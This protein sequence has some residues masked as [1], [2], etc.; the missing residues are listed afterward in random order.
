MSQEMQLG[1]ILK[2]QTGSGKNY[3]KD[4]R[5]LILNANAIGILRKDL[6][7]TLGKEKAKGFLI[8]FGFNNGFRD[9]NNV[10]H[11]FPRIDQEDRYHLARNFHT[12]IGMANVI[13]A[14]KKSNELDH[15]W[16]CEGCWHDSYEAEHHIK[17]FGSATEPVCWTLVGYASGIMSAF[18]GERVI[19]KEVSCVAMGDQ[20]CR[21]VGKKLSDWGEEIRPELQY[22]H[23]T[24][25][26]QG[27]EWPQA[28]IMEQNQALM[29]AVAVH[30]Q[31]TKMVLNGDDMSTIT[32]AVGKIM[33]GAV[34][35]EDHSFQPVSYFSPTMTTEVNQLPPFTTKNIISD[36]RLRHLAVKLTQENK[37]VVLPSE[38][39]KRPITQFVFPI[40]NRMEVI[41]YVSLIK[42]EKKLTEY[43]QM[44][45]EFVVT[46]LALKMMQDSTVA[47]TETRLLGDFVLELITGNFKSESSIVER[48]RCL[49]YKIKRSHRVL[50]ASLDKPACSLERSTRTEG[51]TGDIR[52][53]LCGIINTALGMYNR[54]GTATVT[55]DNIVILTALEDRNSS[56]T[57]E[58][59]RNIQKMIAKHLPSITI[60]IG[61]GRV[62]FTPQD[63]S[64]SYQEA[65]WALKVIKSLNQKNMVIPFDCLG[66][67]GLLFN[68]N[69]E[70]SLMQFMNDQ[71][72]GLLEY[73]NKHGSQ[74]VETLNHYYNCNCNMKE[75]AKATMVT[76]SGFKYRIG[77]ICEV[78][79]F[80][81][82]DPNKRFDLQLALKI[83]CLSNDNPDDREPLGYVR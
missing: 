52:E 49:G 57:V 10:M 53:Q 5:V 39:T 13:S 15:N 22:Y 81:L 30:D 23:G 75:A 27:M 80:S 59:A 6:I 36:W 79:N 19:I 64:D 76:L 20:Q 65:K 82:K 51:Q 41:G 74:L 66:T 17:H 33:N 67:F 46:V 60:S 35:V 54:T 73:D 40:I 70:S 48:A 21:Y 25:L 62:C 77:K 37:P 32:G 14:E 43:E 26:G 47:K 3:L 56:N 9:V 83:W 8:R 4:K 28:S 55:G 7:Y 68:T 42:T 31:L 2:L 38:L 1:H 58:L 72:G 12:F 18:F 71:L 29:Q 50:V 24:T 63:F 61:L 34:M 16:M 45:M 44:T 78:G 69:N 11:D